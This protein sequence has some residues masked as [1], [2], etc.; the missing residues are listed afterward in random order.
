VTAVNQPAREATEYDVIVLGAGAGGEN[1]ADRAVQG[2]STAVLVEHEL[3]GGECS[4]WACT[5]SNA[6][7][8]SAQALHAAQQV[9][10]AAEAITGELDVQAIRGRR[11]SFTNNWSDDSQVQW[12]DGAG[13]SLARGHGRITG[14]KEV[15][16][17]AADG[18]ASVLTARHAVVVATGSDPLIPGIDVRARCAWR[19]SFVVERFRGRGAAP[20]AGALR[21]AIVR[22]PRVAGAEHAEDAD[23]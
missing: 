13:I 16:V 7:L 5:P 1:V 22:R 21:G 14:P 2:G 20:V 11:D 9:P 17:T 12:A 15:T 23:G 10:G 18:S 6:L 4:Y 8:R 19:V 3:V